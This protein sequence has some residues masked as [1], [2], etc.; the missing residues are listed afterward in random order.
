MHTRSLARLLSMRCTSSCAM[1]TAPR[2]CSMAWAT[3]LSSWSASSP[4]PTSKSPS[5]QCLYWGTSRGRLAMS[6]RH[7]S[8]AV[9]VGEGGARAAVSCGAI[10]ALAMETAA[11]YIRT[12]QV[13]Q[14]IRRRAA[15]S[16]RAPLRLLLPT[17]DGTDYGITCPRQP[18][19][20]ILQSPWPL[21]CTPARASVPSIGS[22]TNS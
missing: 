8:G 13:E 21:S 9:G 14:P 22:L 5:P 3:L 20:H 6:W 1:C 12:R 16:L 17:R 19:P 2:S 4:T 11:K 7:T 10:A 15:V 18:L